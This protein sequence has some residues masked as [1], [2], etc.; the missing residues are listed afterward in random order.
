MER[1][2][3]TLR[4]L[5]RNPAVKALMRIRTSDKLVRNEPSM[6]QQMT[7]SGAIAG[8]MRFAVQQDEEQPRRE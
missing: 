1:Q 8:A 2:G 4:C 3:S 6:R 5:M 7:R